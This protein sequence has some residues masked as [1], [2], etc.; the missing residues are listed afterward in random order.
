MLA[1]LDENVM[2]HIQYS[3]LEDNIEIQDEAEF[4]IER[5]YYSFCHF[6][7]TYMTTEDDSDSSFKCQS[8]QIKKSLK[9]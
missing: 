9:K 6:Y 7:A 8:P 5:L 3:I 1:F 2:K 4:L